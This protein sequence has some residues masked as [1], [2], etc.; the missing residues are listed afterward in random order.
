VEGYRQK[1]RKGERGKESGREGGNGREREGE[2][3]RGKEIFLLGCSQK[4]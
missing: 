2:G 4:E 1:Q 3:G